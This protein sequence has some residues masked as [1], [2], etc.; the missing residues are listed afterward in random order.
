[1]CFAC[2]IV[3][4]PPGPPGNPGKPGEAGEAGKRTLYDLILCLLLV[5]F[6]QLGV[7]LTID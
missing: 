5:I 7:L 6:D 2:Q 1:M 3:F 4:A